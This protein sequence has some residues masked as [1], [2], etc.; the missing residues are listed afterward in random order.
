MAVRAG[1]SNAMKIALVTFVVLF[2]ISAALAVIF[3]LQAEEL[4]QKHQS[5]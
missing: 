5:G 2:I 4:F 3:Y 1:Q